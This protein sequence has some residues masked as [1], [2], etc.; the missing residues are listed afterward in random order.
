MTGIPPFQETPKK[1][2]YVILTVLESLPPFIWKTPPE[3]MVD[4][5]GP[6]NEDVSYERGLYIY[7]YHIDIDIVYTSNQKEQH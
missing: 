3:T 4:V 7:I 6:Y 5:L 2:I 1:T